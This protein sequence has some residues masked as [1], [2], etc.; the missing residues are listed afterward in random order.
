MSNITIADLPEEEK[1]KVSRLVDRLVSLGKENEEL[2][3]SISTE[4]SRHAAEIDEARR[5]IDANTKQWQTQISERN[6]IVDEL[7]SK[8]SMALSMMHMYQ[9]KMLE[10]SRTLDNYLQIY[11][12][13]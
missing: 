11:D 7:T 2:Q 8:R 3:S 1:L 9:T 6:S 5:C 4:Q 13:S 10:L 12:I